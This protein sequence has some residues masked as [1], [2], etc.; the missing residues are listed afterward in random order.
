LLAEQALLG[1]IRVQALA[2]G[3]PAA[4]LDMPP[5]ADPL[6]HNQP[7]AAPPGGDGDGDG[8]NLPGKN[9]KGLG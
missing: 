2:N 1:A 7:A 4:D 5:F 3:I 9:L 8:D 6:Q